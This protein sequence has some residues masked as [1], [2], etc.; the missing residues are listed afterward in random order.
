MTAPG[1]RAMARSVSANDETLDLSGL[2]CPL[3]VLKAGKRLR[4]MQQG[5]VLRVIATDPM[6]TIDMPHYCAEQGLRLLEQE[7]ANGIFTFR[8]ERT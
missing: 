7:E 8:I 3:P 6:S 4:A 2:L 5:A 1:V